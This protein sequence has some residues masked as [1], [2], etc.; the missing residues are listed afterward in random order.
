MIERRRSARCTRVTCVVPGRTASCEFGSP[1]RSPTTP[2]PTRRNNSTECSGR[3]MSES[4]VIRSVGASSAR[5][6]S[7]GMSWTSRSI[8]IFLA[9]SASNA[10]GSGAMRTYS[11]CQGLPTIMSGVISSRPCRSSGYTDRR[12][13]AVQQD[14]RPTATVDLVVHLEAV[15]LGVAFLHIDLLGVC[16][17]GRGQWSDDRSHRCDESSVEHVS[18]LPVYHLFSHR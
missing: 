13:R 12:E 7:A 3:M 15:H 8:C 5:I 2:P 16:R 14:Q 6:D 18:T 11:L 9:K 1:T 17:Q 4:P 10:S